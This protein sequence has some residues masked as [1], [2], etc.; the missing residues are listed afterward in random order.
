MKQN[1]CEVCFTEGRGFV[2]AL[3]SIDEQQL[4]KNCGVAIAQ[5]MGDPVLELT[6]QAKARGS[7]LSAEQ[8]ERPRTGPVERI[9]D[10]VDAVLREHEAVASVEVPAVEKSEEEKPMA[11]S[12]SEPGCTKALTERN[13]SGRC[14]KHWYKRKTDGL[15]RGYKKPRVKPSPQRI[16]IEPPEEPVSDVLELKL[17]VTAEWLENAWSRFPLDQKLAAVAHVLQS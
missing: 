17:S 9:A 10:V 13:S 16:E 6:W 3:G 5:E 4:C 1:N 12:C 7:G 2:A 8:R 11:Q 14:S 15:P